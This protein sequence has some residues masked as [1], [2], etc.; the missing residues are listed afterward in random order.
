MALAVIG[1]EQ[2]KLALFGANLRDA[3][4]EVADREGSRALGLVAV[5]IRQAAYAVTLQ[6]AMQR[7]TGQMRQALLQ[8]VEAVVQW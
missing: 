2:V 4:V 5:G 7:R 1:H 6:A 3:Q 8:C